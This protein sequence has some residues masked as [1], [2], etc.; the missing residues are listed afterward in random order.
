MLT[1]WDDD[2]AEQLRKNMLTLE[3]HTNNLPPFVDSVLF[4]V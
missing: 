2:A 1:A 4:N 3:K